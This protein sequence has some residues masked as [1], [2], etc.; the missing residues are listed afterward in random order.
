MAGFSLPNGSLPAADYGVQVAEN[1]TRASGTGAAAAIVAGTVALLIQVFPLVTPALMKIALRRTSHPIDGDENS[2]GAGLIDVYSAYEYLKQYLNVGS[3]YKF[4]L[5]APL[6][7]PGALVSIDSLNIS[8]TESYK[9]NWQYWD[10]AVMM[11]TQAMMTAAIIANSSTPNFS[12]IFLPLNQFG[13]SYVLEKDPSSGNEGLLGAIDLESLLRNP[14]HKSFHW[15]SEFEVLRE[16]HLASDLSTG[17]E[18]HRRYA[19]VLEYGP[20]LVVLVAET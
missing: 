12:E 6:V 13:V 4:P 14:E 19:G 3:I 2:E 9:S 7:Y 17:L 8:R 15:F 18:Q 1:Y 20:L 5:T 16:L 11:S 10:S